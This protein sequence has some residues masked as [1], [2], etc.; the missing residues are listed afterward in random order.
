MTAGVN[1][2]R[3]DGHLHGGVESRITPAGIPIHRFTLAHE[4]SQVE[5]GMVREA[6]CQIAVVA[7]GETLAPVAG[8]LQE[9][10]RVVVEGFI[11]RSSFRDE[12]YR[13]VL[14][15]QAIELLR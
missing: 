2:L 9:G 6:R 10:D 1:R 14:H 7:S 3:L 8:S 4:S 13:I 15:A 5:A 12:S 11:S